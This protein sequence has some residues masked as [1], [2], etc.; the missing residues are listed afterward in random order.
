MLTE[1]KAEFERHEKAKEELCKQIVFKYPKHIHVFLKH[2]LVMYKGFKALDYWITQASIV[3]YCDVSRA[4]P[5]FEDFSTEINIPFKFL[6]CK[7]PEQYLEENE[8][9]EREK[10]RLKEKEDKLNK[11]E[12]E[13]Q[14][15]ANEIKEMLK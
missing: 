12:R 10:L 7:D 6:K 8:K 14:R 11:L 13:K 3:V 4:D 5:L 2:S 1:V 9:L 15:I